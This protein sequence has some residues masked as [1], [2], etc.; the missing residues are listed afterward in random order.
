MYVGKDGADDSHMKHTC[1]T[2]GYKQPLLWVH[3]TDWQKQLLAWYGN[4]IS[5]IDATYKT[6]KYDL[7]LFFV[8]IRTN[9]SYSVVAEFVV[10]SDSADN[11]EEALQKL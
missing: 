5:L 1:N 10:Q 7:A 6:T 9:V 2:G 3:Q 8:C 11:V 4:T